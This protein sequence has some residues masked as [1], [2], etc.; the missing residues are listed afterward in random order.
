MLQ[1]QNAKIGVL[2]LLMILS[3]AIMGIHTARADSMSS[4]ET[5]LMFNSLESFQVNCFADDSDGQREPDLAFTEEIVKLAASNN[6][7]QRISALSQL[8]EKSPIDAGVVQKVLQ[9][10]ILDKDSNVRGQA[11]YAIAQQACADFP[12]LLEQ[13]LNDSELSVRMMAVDSLGVD[14]KGVSLLEQ[15]LN[16]DEEAVRELAAMKLEAHKSH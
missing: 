1:F 12:I 4:S 14:E 13:A 3:W 5:K 2:I 16:D 7:E 10:A 8:A 15:A 11:V 6:P 9:K